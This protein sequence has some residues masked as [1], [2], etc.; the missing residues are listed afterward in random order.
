MVIPQ[1]CFRSHL[2]DGEKINYI[3]HKHIWIYRMPLFKSLF[4]GVIVPLSLFFVFPPLLHIWLALAAVGALWFLYHLSDWYFD[5]W[6][7]TNK[8]ILD[9]E[10]NGF[11]HRS[12]TRIEYHTINGVSYE[13]NGFWG[14]LFG[15]GDITVD[16]FGSA[17]SF[18]LKNGASPKELELEILRNQERFVQD[19]SYR[20]HETLK[21][22]L[23]DML[24]NRN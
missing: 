12:S 20:D 8:G 1:F 11:F 19:K 22:M 4:L 15:Y 3:A 6:L 9:I 13:I 7:V 16:T 5:V 17:T 10:W 18:I 2:D 23:A 21:S 24:Q 14:T